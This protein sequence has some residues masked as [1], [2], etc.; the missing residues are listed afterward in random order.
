[1]PCIDT[2]T[3]V[4]NIFT[5]CF[6]YSSDDDTTADEDGWDEE[7]EEE[8]PPQPAKIKFLKGSMLRNM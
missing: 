1:M 8:T 2:K 4:V 3:V 6:W 5:V 7:E